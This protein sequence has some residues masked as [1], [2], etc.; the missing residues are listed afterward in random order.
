M[1]EQVGGGEGSDTNRVCSTGV[2]LHM[3]KSLVMLGLVNIMILMQLMS[4]STVITEA[5]TGTMAVTLFLSTS[6]NSVMGLLYEED[7]PSTLQVS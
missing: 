4:E 3:W 2:L 6:V 1:V 7:A 5:Q